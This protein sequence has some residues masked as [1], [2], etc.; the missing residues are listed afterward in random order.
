MRNFIK[1]WCCGGMSI[2]T[3]SNLAGMIGKQIM[4]LQTNM[5][6]GV[7]LAI[8]SSPGLPALSSLPSMW[9]LKRI[10]LLKEHVIFFNNGTFQG[11]L[12]KDTN[13]LWNHLLMLG[14]IHLG[15]LVMC[16]LFFYTLMNITSYSHILCFFFGLQKMRPMNLEGCTRKRQK[17]WVPEV[18]QM[19]IELVIS[20][21]RFMTMSLQL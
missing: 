1:G 8:V 2:E 11:I 3:T 10:T 5:K 12:L 21:L 13:F 4:H 15:P 17:K 7:Q 19:K 16:A 14:M 20:C 18:M 6:L 9:C